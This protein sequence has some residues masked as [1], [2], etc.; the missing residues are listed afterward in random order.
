MIVGFGVL[1]V[2]EKI[3]KYFKKLM[4]YKKP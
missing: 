1:S 2:I 3:L 4:F